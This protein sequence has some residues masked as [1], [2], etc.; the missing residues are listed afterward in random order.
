[1]N[2]TNEGGSR[3]ASGSKTGVISCRLPYDLKLAAESLSRRKS[4][5][6]SHILRDFVEATVALDDPDWWR[7]YA[8]MARAE[9]ERR[10][11]E[12][13]GQSV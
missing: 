1:M 4:I 5:A 13:A 10:K 11:A 2:M 6:L 12:R 9:E 3:S 8:E 7:P